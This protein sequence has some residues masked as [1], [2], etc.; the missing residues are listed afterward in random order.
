MKKTLT[1][2][3]TTVALAIAPAMWAQQAETPEGAAQA[4]AQGAEQSLTGCLAGEQGTFTLKTS[5]GTV[6]LEGNGLQ[7]HVGHTIRVSGTQS[8]V[9]GKSVFQ[10][11]DVEMV[12]SSCQT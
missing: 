1:I 2:G 4:Q 7:G 3:I 10:V 5:S 6:Q 12:S 11:T 9:A 8:T